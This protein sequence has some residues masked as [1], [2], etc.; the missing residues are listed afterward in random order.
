V[1]KRAENEKKAL[2]EKQRLGPVCKEHVEK[3]LSHVLSLKV[4]AQKDILRIHSGLGLASVL[5]DG[6]EVPIYKLNKA[7]YEA[8]LRS[9][10]KSNESNTFDSI[11]EKKI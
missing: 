10:I 6:V 8:A 11:V 7:G 9:L 2:E 1:V 4:D 5:I 3:G